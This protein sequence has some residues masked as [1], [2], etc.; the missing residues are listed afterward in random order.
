MIRLPLSF[1]N[2]IRTIFI[3]AISITLLFIFSNVWTFISNI[4]E[5]AISK[6]SSKITSEFGYYID[7]E[8]NLSIGSFLDNKETT[9]LFIDSLASDIPYDLGYQSYWVKIKISNISP[10]T[11]NLVLLADNSMLE[12]FNVYEINS[13]LESATLITQKKPTFE[14]EK[15]TK[16]FPHID[17]ELIET[18]TVQ[19]IAH[20]KSNGPP[21]IPLIIF[22]K[23]NF[24]DRI[25]HAQIVFGIFIGMILLMAAYNFVLYFAIKDKVYLVYIGYLLTS[26]IV[27]AGVTGYGYLIFSKKVQYF[28]HEYLLF[29]HFFLVLFLLLFSLFYL[30]YDQ[31][32]KNIY[33]IGIISSVLLVLFALYSLSLD[34]IAQTKLFFSIQPIYILFSLFIIFKRLSKD[35]AWARFYFISW[36]PFLAG[37]SIQPLVLLNYIESTFLTQNAY[38]FAVMIE[39]TFMAFA[40]AERMRRNDQDRVHDICYH[41]STDLPRKSMLESAMSKLQL[42]GN[43]NFCVMV[44]KPEHIEQISLYI[45]DKANADLFKRLSHRLSSLFIHND[46]VVSLSP[47]QEKICLLEN[48]CLAIIVNKKKDTQDLSVLIKSIQQLVSETF[49]IDELKICRVNKFIFRCFSF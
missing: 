3:V 28:I 7:H 10:I 27:L 6:D 2:L 22:T 41:D 17:F 25:D 40:L 12:I 33:K 24:E 49:Q 45:D 21:N 5:L 20:V 19:L 23:E 30:R 32:K 1:Y 44:I 39:I 46:A 42:S 15:L 48:N 13:N 47:H 8:N 4:D 35:F 37:A 29:T 31:F 18:S 34:H 26:F 11:Q 14:Q 43:N 38:L 9:P 16:L 36:I